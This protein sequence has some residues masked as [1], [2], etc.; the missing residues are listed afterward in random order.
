MDGCHRWNEPAATPGESITKE[1]RAQLRKLIASDL[2]P[3][4]H[5]GDLLAT[6]LRVAALPMLDALDRAEVEREKALEYIRS[7]NH[8]DCVVYNP[9]AMC[10]SCIS[11]MA[12]LTSLKDKP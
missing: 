1:Q 10:V 3:Q 12:F 9:T 4:V 6:T 2:P 8:V 7:L 5:P 11:N